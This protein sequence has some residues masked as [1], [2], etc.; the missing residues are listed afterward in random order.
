MDICGIAPQAAHRREWRTGSRHTAAALDGGN[1]RGFLAA[2]IGARTAF[3]R[4]IE[5]EPRTGNVLAEQAG[6]AHLFDGEFQPLE[7]RSIFHA[8]INVRRGGIHG[9]PGNEHAFQH[10]MG[11]ALD[12]RAVHEGAGVALGAIADEETFLARAVPAELPLFERGKSGATATAKTG[13]FHLL[14][15]FFRANIQS[16]KKTPISVTGKVMMK[17]L[18]VNNTAVTKNTAHLMAHDRMV[19]QLRDTIGC[20]CIHDAQR[21]L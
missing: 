19:T 13:I 9:I 20:F 7:H 8:D 16:A 18:R 4:D 14:Q 17:I 12:K 5:R 21:P 15:C 11:I 6:L 3:Y 10:G 1:Q 2:H